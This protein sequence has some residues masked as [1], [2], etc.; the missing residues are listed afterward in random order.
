MKQYDDTFSKITNELFYVREESG[1]KI[2]YSFEKSILYK[3]GYD[4]KVILILH[5]LFLST[6]LR[7]KSL[8]TLDYLIEKCGYKLDKDNRKCFKDTLEKLKALEIINYN[9]FKKSNELIIID[10]EQIMLNVEKNFTQLSDEEINKLDIIK[11]I[12]L[13]VSL[14]KLYLYLKARTKKRT[15]SEDLNLYCKSQTTYQSYEVIERYTNI[16]QSRI[17]TYIDKLQDIKLITYRKVGYRYKEQDLKKVKTE[18]PNVYAINCLQDD[19]EAELE[20]GIKQCKHEQE[21]KGY[22]VTQETYK[23]HDNQKIGLYGSLIK[24]KNNNKITQKEIRQLI[25]IEKEMEEYKIQK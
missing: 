1:D 2:N 11:D 7:R 13:K 20:I 14:L 9:D 17:K 18:C 19:I 5:E 22:I 24:K 3:T 10:T 25:E 8:I 16:S 21:E 4:D 23:N 6:T 12:R 15:T